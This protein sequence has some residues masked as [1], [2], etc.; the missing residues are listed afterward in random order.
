MSV[1]EEAL[2][3]E[4]VY[5]IGHIAHAEQHSIEIDSQLEEPRL[6]RVID[7]LRTARKE[8]GRIL[9]E[10][11]GLKSESDGG[12]FRTG[13]ENTWCA[14]KHLSMA[15]IHCDECIEKVLRRIARGDKRAAKSLLVL[16]GTRNRIFDALKDVVRSVGSLKEAESIRCRED[17]CLEDKE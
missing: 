13:S 7:S 11:T 6:V 15:L 8:A 3:E 5:L 16:Y 17:L 2:I 1:E 14:L 12:E 9:L 4:L 10:V